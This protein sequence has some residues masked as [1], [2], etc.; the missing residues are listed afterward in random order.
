MSNGNG[1]VEALQRR[2][3]EQR[4]RLDQSAELLAMA[5]KRVTRAGADVDA[6]ARE[7]AAAKKARTTPPTRRLRRATR[8]RQLAGWPR[9]RPQS[10]R[11]P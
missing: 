7:Y 8:P 2:V 3:E 4:T 9:P 11:R 10:S 1:D 5:Q 6:S